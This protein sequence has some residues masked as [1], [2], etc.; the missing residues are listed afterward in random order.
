MALGGIA[1]VVALAVDTAGR[2]PVADR[3][4][5]GTS[6]G[7]RGTG[8]PPG[9][10]LPAFALHDLDGR[11]VTSADLRGH[12]VVVAFFDS[13][14]GSA[15]PVIAAQL[16]VAL[17][18]LSAAQRRHLLALAISMNPHNDTPPSARRFLRQHWLLG[19]VRYLIGSAAQL[20]PV[21]RAFY[22]LSSLQSGNADVHSDDV[23]VFDRAGRWVSDFAEGVDLTP[24]NIAHDI[25]FALAG[26]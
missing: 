6:A 11:A 17:D 3:S 24:E 4:S 12:V 19:R 8:L 22:V 10:R 16:G 21:W 14:C 25:R 5:S 20:R 15:C 23:R 1:A 2:L 7:Y 9:L 18:E 13:H 26:E